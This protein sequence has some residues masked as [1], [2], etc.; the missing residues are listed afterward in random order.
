MKNI[1]KDNKKL[2]FLLCFFMTIQP[3]LDINVL[4]E[5]SRYML[6]GITIPT[7]VRTAFIGII[8]L[9]IIH[10]NRGAK[11][12]KY[13]LLYLL[14]VCIYSLIHHF[15][16]IGEMEVLDSFKY[17]L[18]TELFYMIRMI[19]PMIIIYITKHVKVDYQKY[20]NVILISS[21]IIGS[22]IV[23]G[24]LLLISYTS[25]GTDDIYTKA[26]FISWIFSDV[27]K[28]TFEE[29]TSKGW[30]YMANQVA[31]LTLLLLP[32]CI[33]DMFK[34]ISIK[35]V[36]AVILLTLSMI[37][38][39]TRTSAY[40][41]ILVYISIIIAFYTLCLMKK[42]KNTSYKP[43]S[44]IIILAFVFLPLLAVSPIKNRI[45]TRNLKPNI[46]IDSAMQGN[47]VY[48]YI[49]EYYPY[50]EIKKIY[51][52]DLYSYKYDYVFWLDVF[53]KAKDHILDN[54]EIE[55]L[56]TNRIVEKN[57]KLKYK[58]F[59][60]SFS[61]MRNGEIYI[62]KDFYAQRVTIGYIGLI[63]FILPYFYFIGYIMIKKYKSHELTIELA[64]FII[65][66][67][68][69]FGSSIYTGHILDELFVMLYVGFIIG[70]YLSLGGKNESKC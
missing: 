59:G 19:L 51:I 45:Y 24:N 15:V 60:Y 38:L 62:E 17:S 33:S 28:Y 13:I 21:I 54:R 68:A 3:L 41:W 14:L 53:E 35:N 52:E 22:V 27:S 65:S 6:F 47:D 44:I 37:I 2:V 32:L 46:P 48:K 31:G 16:D 29:L 69:L 26:S 57:D 61:R 25:Y 58:L 39:G 67:F 12:N 64:S 70:Y 55:L 36:T 10:K 8:G 30:F 43:I 18:M 9:Y 7:I 49:K 1:L 5:D 34:K 4:F 56:I 20:I 42:I 40:G 50:Y 66:M 63:I 23:I 11:E